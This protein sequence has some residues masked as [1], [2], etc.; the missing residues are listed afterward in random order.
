MIKR[1]SWISHNTTV[2]LC[3]IFCSMYFGAFIEAQA[4]IEKASREQAA[5]VEAEISCLG[6]IAFREARNQL[7]G[8]RRL[9]M[10]VVIARRDDPLNRWPKTI[11]GN[12]VNG[13]IS[14]VF[15]EIKL[16]ARDVA[17]LRENDEIAREVYV[18][19]W[20]EQLLPAGWE[21]VRFWRLSDAE[22]AKLSEKQRGQLGI[23]DGKGL[24]FFDRLQ[25]VQTHGSLTFFGNPKKCGPL[26]T[27]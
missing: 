22:I 15:K 23:V 3:V 24:K 18:E 11:C 6:N 14:Q 20:K 1:L 5:F 21:C 27:T 9:L 25:P 17:S 12:A 2:A 4:G 16:N 10:M 13:E 26:P 19:A 8:P 7:R